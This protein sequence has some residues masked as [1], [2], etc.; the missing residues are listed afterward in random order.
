[1]KGTGV[2]AGEVALDLEAAF[3]VV[4][5]GVRGL[6]ERAAVESWPPERLIEEVGSML[7]APG[8]EVRN[9]QG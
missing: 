9:V 5:E 3:L 7:G 1:M 4:E 6:L 8:E 2:H